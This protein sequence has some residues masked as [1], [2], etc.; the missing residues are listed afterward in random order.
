MGWGPA[1]DVHDAV[2][3]ADV[4]YPWRKVDVEQT[5]RV[6]ETVWRALTRSADRLFRARKLDVRKPIRSCALV[7]WQ[8]KT[9]NRGGGKTS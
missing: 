3:G 1:R 7:S 4:E 6:T 5:I 9:K 8:S 2:C